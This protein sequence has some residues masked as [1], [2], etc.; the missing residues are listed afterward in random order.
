MRGGLTGRGARRGG[1][2]ECGVALPAARTTSGPYARASCNSEKGRG[3][4]P[5]LEFRGR[6]WWMC[7]SGRARVWSGCGLKLEE[8]SCTSTYTIRVHVGT[9]P[10]SPASRPSPDRSAHHQRDHSARY[11]YPP[12]PTPD[13][14]CVCVSLST[15]PLVQRP[16]ERGA[17]DGRRT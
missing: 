6:V 8:G 11:T 1:Q 9:T 17:V 4:E 7:Y 12:P 5:V 10:P 16:G 13:P 14:E 15:R 2:R 3:A